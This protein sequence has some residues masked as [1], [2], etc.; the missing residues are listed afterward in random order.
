MK[1]S[2]KSIMEWHEQTFPDATIV[3]QIH[4]FQE[5]LKEYK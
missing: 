1:E 5:E 4:K 2:I 3:G